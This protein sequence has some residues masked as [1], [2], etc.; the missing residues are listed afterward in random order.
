MHEVSEVVWM[1]T[2]VMTAGL[3]LIARSNDDAP[4]NDVALIGT[5][6]WEAGAALS[7]S[8]ALTV[9]GACSMTRFIPCFVTGMVP[10][11]RIAEDQVKGVEPVQEPV[12]RK[13]THTTSPDPVRGATPLMWIS[14]KPE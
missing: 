1:L 7:V 8:G 11:L 14:M 13:S 12:L 3:K 5:T 4:V 9:T 10:P 6:T 2:G